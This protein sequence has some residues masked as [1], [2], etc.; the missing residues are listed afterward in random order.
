V[1][2]GEPRPGGSGAGA[3]TGYRL[4][5][6]APL[7]RRLWIA[8]GASVVGDFIGQGALLFL[9]VDR[10]GQALGAAA[11]LAVGVLPTLLTGMLAGSWLDRLPR[12]P[13]LVSLQLLGAVVICLPILADGIGV[14]YLTAALLAVVRTGT[15]AVRSGAMAEGL[16]DDQRGP[17][18]ALLSSTDQA[19]QV[20]GYLAG[21]ALYLAL[22][23][24]VALLV[25][26]ASFVAGAVVLATLRL[27]RASGSVER[28]G[29][30]AGL[31]MIGRDPVLRLL[32]VLVVATGMVASLPEVL[33]PVVAGS[34]DPWR[35]FVLAAAPLGQTVTMMVVGRL[36]SVRR[37]STQL[38]HLAWLVLALGITA[39]G[40]SPAWVA[41]GNLLVGSGVAWLVGPQLTFLR[42]APARNMA[43]IS[44]TMV[45]LLAVS[46]GAGS[47]AYA[48]IADVYGVPSAYRTA[49]VVLLV[50]TIGGWLAKERTPA[51]LALDRDEPPEDRPPPP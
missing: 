34:D 11:I 50:V 30:T 41:F 31:R 6:R 2:T 47:L 14:V 48:R 42:L 1:D 51:A 35:P 44:A 10:T 37:P 4:A 40:R 12:V 21:G 17:L 7:V 49:G 15:I 27:P 43:Q 24:T 16:E 18:L 46:D 36:P 33:A 3:A 5:L 13:A 32:A 29:P 20:V 23:T 39:L 19:G 26:S 9:A 25:D 22:G 45:A 38:S 8:T 28:A